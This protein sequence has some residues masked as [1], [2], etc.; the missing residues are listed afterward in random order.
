MYNGWLDPLDSID[1]VC[2]TDHES[3]GAVGRHL[4]DLGHREIVYVHGDKQLRGRRE[5][6]NGLREA[7]EAEPTCR[8]HDLSW[9]ENETF[10]DALNALLDSGAAPT[11]FF[12]SHDGLALTAVTD[13]LSRGWSIPGDV[14]VVGFGDYSAARQIRPPLT[15]I[16]VHGHDIGRSIV[17]MLHNRLFGDSW[18]GAPVRFQIV[19]EF[20]LRGTTGPAPGS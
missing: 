16:R 14:S 13:L 2:G 8:L 20:A 11:A 5:R 17:Q 19:N 9:S 6:L 15:T 3:G 10:T 1:T 4:L 18:P 7:V 12:C